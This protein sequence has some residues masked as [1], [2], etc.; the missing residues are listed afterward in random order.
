MSSLEPGKLRSQTDDQEFDPL[1]PLRVEKLRRMLLEKS[2]PIV[3]EVGDTWV[4]SDGSNWTI[5]ADEPATEEQ[6]SELIVRTG[7]VAKVLDYQ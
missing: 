7:G 3:W 6:V 2:E 1:H 4:V 5:G